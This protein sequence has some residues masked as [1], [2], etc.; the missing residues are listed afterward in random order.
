MEAFPAFQPVPKRNPFSSF[1]SEINFVIQ[2]RANLGSE[3]V[4]LRQCFTAFHISKLRTKG[5][6]CKAVSGK[7]MRLVEDS[8]SGCVLKPPQGS[9]ISAHT[10]WKYDLDQG[11]QTTGTSFFY[12]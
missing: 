8:P 7:C 9:G 1:G 4:S 12:K 6:I 2:G 5:S 3:I 11:A 10:D